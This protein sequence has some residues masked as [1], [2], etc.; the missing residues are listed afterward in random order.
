MFGD[1]AT[2]KRIKL[3]RSLERAAVPERPYIGRGPRYLV[4]PTI[5]AACAPSLLAI[6]A[7]LRER[8]HGVQ[9]RRA[10][11]SAVVH[12]EQL[13]AVLRSRR[14]GGDAR[15]RTSS[16]RSARPKPALRDR[17]QV[18][19][20]DAQAQYQSPALTS[21]AGGT[22]NIPTGTLLIMA[23][24]AAAVITAPAALGRPASSGSLV[25]THETA[26]ASSRCPC[27]VGLLGGPSDVAPRPLTSVF[28]SRCPCN[29]GLPGG[30]N[31]AGH[32]GS[33]PTVG[34]KP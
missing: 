11:A 13:V 9:R 22:M 7:A 17:A 3:A 21:S 6:A 20:A 33:V 32:A 19:Q 2:R 28:S 27:N 18:K 30:P 5:T 1:K 8:P 15:S 34:T 14:D 4:H 16:A 10:E 25:T 23:L 24:L 31:A 26:T 12:H 29:I